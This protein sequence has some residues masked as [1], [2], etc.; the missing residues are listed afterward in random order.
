MQVLL[1]YQSSCLPSGLFMNILHVISQHPASTGSG[2]YL[3]NLLRQAVAAG[4]RNFLV[5][6]SANGWK[7]VLDGIDESSCRFVTFAGGDLDFVMPG[8]SDVMPYASS[9]FSEMT[10]EE[11]S[12]YEDAFAGKIRDITSLFTIDIIHSHHLWLV[13][14]VARRTLP[15]VPM[16]TSCHSTDLR[17]YLRCPHLQEYVLGECRKIDRILALS[18]GQAQQITGLYG[19]EPDRIDVIGSGFDDRLFTFSEKSGERPV[20]LLYAGKLSYAKGVDW[21]LRVCAGLPAADVHLHLVGAGF[22]KEGEQCLKLAR[23]IG[24]GVTVHGV[25]SQVQLARLMQKCHVFILPSFYEGLPLVLLEAL[26]SGCRIVATALPGCRELLAGA[27]ADLVAFVDLPAMSAIDRPDPDDWE[28]LDAR[29]ED[30]IRKMTHRVTV[31]PA[32]SLQ[33]I[34]AIT[35]RAKWELVFSRIEEAYARAHQFRRK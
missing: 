15:D 27:A 17:Q 19:I 25:L 24:E 1:R 32:P 4:H 5:A 29:L 35:G 9:R 14:A 12:R 23:Q 13:S 2:I 31:S 11:V 16:V 7:P 10:A 22:G 20:H 8:M 3:Q 18:S 21:L 6:G 34:T 30:A 33:E 28:E 26:A